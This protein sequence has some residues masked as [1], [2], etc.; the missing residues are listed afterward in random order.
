MKPRVTAGL[1]VGF[2]FVGGVWLLIGGIQRS[3]SRQALEKQCADL[4]GELA[5]LQSNLNAE[6]I[7]W[8]YAFREVEVEDELAWNMAVRKVDGE[9]ATK[10]NAL[11]IVMAKVDRMGAAKPH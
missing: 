4:T 8:Y 1:L 10:S 11:A 5:L 9:I 3:R 7:Q 6:R 2:I